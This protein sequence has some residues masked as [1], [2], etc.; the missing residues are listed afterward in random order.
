[1]I[2][3][4][5]N[6]RK[7]I[8]SVDYSLIEWYQ[9]SSHK[10]FEVFMLISIGI[11]LFDHRNHSWLWM[12]DKS[13]PF[14]VSNELSYLVTPSHIQ[15]FF[16]NS[17]FL[18]YLALIPFESRKTDKPCAIKRFRCSCNLWL[19]WI[20]NLNN[21]RQQCQHNNHNTNFTIIIHHKLQQISIHE[22]QTLTISTI[23]F[24]MY[25]PTNLN[26]MSWQIS[27]Y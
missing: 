21:L 12:L 10:H 11:K 24:T 8:I 7:L 26:I 6:I 5:V 22:S 17:Q 27:S 15:S 3:I 2:L 16:K 4:I 1:M 20:Y 18:N 23:M 9:F 14:F 13:F 25:K 19:F